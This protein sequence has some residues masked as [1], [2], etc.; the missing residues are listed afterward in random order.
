MKPKL[1]EGEQVSGA[2][3]LDELDGD[4]LV[5]SETRVIVPSSGRMF[6]ADGRMKVSV[7]RPC[8]SKGRRLRGLSPIYTP[9]MLEANAA[10]FTGWP[11]YQDHLMEQAVEDLAEELLEMGGEDLLASLQERARQIKDL[12]GRVVESYWNPDL[13]F[14]DDADYGFQKGGVE[15]IV[16]PQ[17]GIRKMLEADPE[18]LNVS[19]N[20]YPTGG[21]AGTTPWGGERGLLIEGIRRKPM[22]SV[23]WVFRGGAGGRPLLQES[24]DERRRAAVVLEGAYDYDHDESDLENK[25]DREVKKLSE[26]TPDELREHLSNEGASHLIPAL[27]EGTAPTEG[28]SEQKVATM[29]AESNETILSELTNSLREAAEQN[30]EALIERLTEQR[31]N[32]ELAT[33][34]GEIIDAAVRG[35]LSERQ[36]G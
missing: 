4:T 17:P 24:S 32:V 13:T 33:L 15:A 26:M 18:I 34:A 8:I 20:A 6:D 35:G 14:P 19:I 11:M 22:G 12:G 25:G 5:E 2:T 27:A 7:I 9:Q 3:I 31:E 16:I 29:I 10:V 1:T 21:K 36:A 30:N 28:M 23:D